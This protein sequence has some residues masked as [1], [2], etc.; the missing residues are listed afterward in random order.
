MQWPELGSPPLQSNGEDEPLSGEEG[1]VER[2]P[3]PVNS[4]ADE[5]ILMPELELPVAANL[6]EL[7]QK[8]DSHIPGEVDPPTGPLPGSNYLPERPL[9][10]QAAA[11]IHGNQTP[12]PAAPPVKKP[13]SRQKKGV[14]IAINFSPS[15]ASS[16]TGMQP[17]GVASMQPVGVAGT[18]PGGVAGMQPVG[19][20]G[21]QP[22]GV[23]GMQPVGVARAQ[24]GNSTTSTIVAMPPLQDCGDSDSQ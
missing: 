2:S 3:R 7:P 24:L 14:K 6:V 22:G 17:G 20:A 5:Q 13:T 18:Q 15:Q 11:N 19:V 21:M 16:A 10:S 8:G 12:S 9:P 1:E 23:A 4:T